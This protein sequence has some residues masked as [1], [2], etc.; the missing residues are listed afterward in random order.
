MLKTWISCN[1]TVKKHGH[2]D[3]RTHSNLCG[4]VF[5][6]YGNKYYQCFMCWVKENPTPIRKLGL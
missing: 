2:E 3:L 1:C 5:S 6:Q 4:A